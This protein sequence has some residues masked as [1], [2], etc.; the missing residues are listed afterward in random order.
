MDKNDISDLS[1]T[2]IKHIEKI[3]GKFIRDMIKDYVLYSVVFAAAFTAVIIL[4]YYM[5]S[6]FGTDILINIFIIFLALFAA[7]LILCAVLAAKNAAEKFSFFSYYYALGKITAYENTTI[8]NET[9]YVEYEVK[10]SVRRIVRKIKYDESAQILT[11]L[12]EDVQFR[13]M[14]IS[15]KTYDCS[16]IGKEAVIIY[17]P[18]LSI[19]LVIPRDELNSTKENGTENPSQT[20]F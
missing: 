19:S 16:V 10:R 14:P 13:S 15:K 18:K 11:A 8:E 2:E 3:A 1:V 6:E 9:A 17:Y 20:I 12:A 5:R 4:L 7:A